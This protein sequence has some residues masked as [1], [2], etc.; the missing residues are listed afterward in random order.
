M[1][2]AMGDGDFEIRRHAHG[3]AG[4]AVARGQGGKRAEMRRG[5]FGLGRDAHQAV[6]RQA[7]GAGRGDKGIHAVGQDAGLLRLG[8]GVDLDEELWTL[9]AG[10][11]E[12]GEFL[13]EARPV[14]AVDRVEKLNRL[15]RLVGLQGADHVQVDPAEAGGEVRPSRGGLLHVVLAEAAVAFSQHSLDPAGWLEFGDGDECDRSG[16][17]GCR[18]FCG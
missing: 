12:A 1:R 6:E 11:G 15:L 3:Q 10:L 8:P 16:R 2:G 18:C 13:Q 7:F 5:V 14:E 17:P 4:Q 9:P